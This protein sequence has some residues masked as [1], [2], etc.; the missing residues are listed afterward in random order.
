M[1]IR[2][3]MRPAYEWTCH[4]CG[5]SQFESAMLAEFNEED[6]LEAA[7]DLGLLDEFADEI[8]EDMTGDFVTYPTRVKCRECG[9]EFETMHHSEDLEQ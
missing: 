5:A 2:A 7:K 4:D 8:P 9:A 3:E 1:T 6:R